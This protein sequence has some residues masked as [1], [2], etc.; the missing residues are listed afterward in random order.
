[1]APDFSLAVLGRHWLT[2]FA[3]PF[4]PWRPNIE[5]FHA[6]TTDVVVAIAAG[7]ALHGALLVVAARRRPAIIAAYLILYS[8]PLLPVVAL[9]KTENHYLYG[10][11]VAFAFLLVL[12]ARRRAAVRWFVLACI[13]WTSLR[14]IGRAH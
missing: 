6:P 11:A 1:Y 5:P 12:A 13:A 14:E 3:V 2:Y 7:A 10:S 9:P 4:V 8:L